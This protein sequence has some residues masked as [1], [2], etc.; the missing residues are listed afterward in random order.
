MAF[1]ELFEKYDRL[2]IFDTETTGLSAQTCK[3]TETERND[4]C[5]LR[6]VEIKFFHNCG[7]C[8]SLTALTSTDSCN[9]IVNYINCFSKTF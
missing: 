2:V 4:C 1:S 6:F 7:F 8:F 5:C 3:L 9:N